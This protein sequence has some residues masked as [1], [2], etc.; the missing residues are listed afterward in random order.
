MPR[1]TYVYSFRKSAWWV[2]G[3]SVLTA[4]VPLISDLLTMQVRNRA[5]WLL[6]IEILLPL[7][8][9]SIP[10]VWPLTVEQLKSWRRRHYKLLPNRCFHCGY[11]LRESPGPRC[12]ECGDP[13]MHRGG[14]DS[15]S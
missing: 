3:L 7:T 5:M 2:V 10:F 8:A 11:D 12:P 15:E 9:G 4:S 1:Q 6:A 13:M 14:D